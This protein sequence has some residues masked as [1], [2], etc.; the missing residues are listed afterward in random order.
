MLREN[1]LAKELHL[2]KAKHNLDFANWLKE[3][4]K[5]EL[6]ELFGDERFYDWVINAYYYATIPCRFSLDCSKRTFF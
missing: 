2:R 6:P 1:K 5:R 3:K 4:H